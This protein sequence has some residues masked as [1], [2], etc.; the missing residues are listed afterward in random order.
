MDAPVV[1]SLR[2][3]QGTTDNS[4]GI[5]AIALFHLGPALSLNGVGGRALPL[6]PGA[7][8]RGYTAMVHFVSESPA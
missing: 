3:V 7:S 8:L 2:A 1:V 6:S 5:R 4:K